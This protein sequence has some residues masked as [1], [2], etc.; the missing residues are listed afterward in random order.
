M[1][2]CQKCGR[3]FPRQNQTHS[4]KIWPIENHF[5]NKELARSLFDEFVKRIREDVGEF[6]VRSLQCCIHLDTHFT[7]VA[8]FPMKDRI[9]LHFS[10]DHKI[11]SPR[12]AEWSQYSKKRFMHR[13]EI[14]NREEINIEIIKWIKEAYNFREV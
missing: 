13:V 8:V 5:K 7:F 14:K 6:E 12:I 2:K 3:E 10:V 11:E 9:R 1:W 4:C